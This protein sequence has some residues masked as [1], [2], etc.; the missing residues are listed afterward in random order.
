MI[1][2]KTNLLLHYFSET[3]VFA[4]KAIPQRTQFG[5]LEGVLLLNEADNLKR[6]PTN[7]LLYLIETE[8]TIYRLDVS[9]ESMYYI[10]LIKLYCG[11]NHICRCLQLD[12]VCTEG[13]YI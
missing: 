11:T 7:S 10:H 2:V 8:G 13:T 6:E 9:D 1:V 4:K 3:A 12:V 5:P